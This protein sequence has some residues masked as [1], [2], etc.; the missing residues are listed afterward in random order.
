MI[1]REISK[2]FR[3]NIR[4]VSRSKTS[5]SFSLRLINK[6]TYDCRYHCNSLPLKSSNSLK[7]INCMFSFQLIQQH[8]AHAEY[9]TRWTTISKRIDRSMREWDN[10]NSHTNKKKSITR[11]ELWCIGRDLSHVVAYWHGQWSRRDY[12]L[13]WSVNIVHVRT[14]R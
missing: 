8:D 13:T 2:S 6:K 3:I 1:L 4:I 7:Y 9:W 5:K 10:S 12:A 14:R 11:N